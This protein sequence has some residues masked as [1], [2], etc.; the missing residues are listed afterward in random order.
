MRIDIDLSANNYGTSNFDNYIEVADRE[1]KLLQNIL[2][3]LPTDGG[4]IPMAFRN[5][6][7]KNS[8]SI[9]DDGFELLPIDNKIEDNNNNDDDDE[10]Y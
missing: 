3:L 9:D 5:V 10:D 8:F 2:Y 6:N 1:A 7:E 4:Q